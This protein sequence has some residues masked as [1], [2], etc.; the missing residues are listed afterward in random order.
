MKKHTL[1]ALAL[2]IS[3]LSFAASDAPAKPSSA[4]SQTP[5]SAQAESL[6]NIFTKHC[7]TNFGNEK[8]LLDGLKGQ[9]AAPEAMTAAL[10]KDARGQ[11]WFVPGDAGEYAVAVAQNGSSCK[12]FARRAAPDAVSSRFARLEKEAPPAYTIKKLPDPAEQAAGIHV[13]SYLVNA[14]N[15]G[16]TPRRLVVTVETHSAPNSMFTAVA[17]VS[18]Q[19]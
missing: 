16:D 10:L 1:G 8:A 13:R 11:A 7:L 17:S 5:G 2:C 4:P 12:A 6:F 3:S 15:A 19:K 9:Q 14:E 18:A